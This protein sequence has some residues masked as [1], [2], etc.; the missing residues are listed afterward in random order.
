MG[1]KKFKMIEKLGLWLRFQYPALKKSRKK[2]SLNK[3]TGIFKLM[4]HLKIKTIGAGCGGALLY[5]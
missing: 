2:S 4:L 5:S 3:P 1:E